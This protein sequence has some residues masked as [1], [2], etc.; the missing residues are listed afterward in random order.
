MT[1]YA[2]AFKAE[3]ARQ[4][5]KEVKRDV[6]PLRKTVTAQRSEI[7]ALKRD[8]KAVSAQVARMAKSK[9]P[10][11]ASD[12]V[13]QVVAQRGGRKF[14]FRPEALAAKRAALGVT[15]QEMAVLLGASMA[16]ASKWELGKASPR[17]AQVDRIRVVLAMGVRE[18][19]RILSQ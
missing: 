11:S 9:A 6:A 12:G 18:A 8:L 3:V 4:V 13:E 1:A 5:R 15:Q 17:A 7:A 10:S 19:R 16:S 2:E 14:V